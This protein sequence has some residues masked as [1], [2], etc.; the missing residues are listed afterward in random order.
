MVAIESA[1][2]SDVGKKREE[3]ED[4]YLVD[5]ELQL[6]LVADGMGGH[7]AGE[8]ASSM[9]VQAI[10]E[11]LLAERAAEAG[12]EADETLSPDANRLLA[13]VKTANRVVV[14]R[15]QQEEQCR[16]MGSTVS[17][18]YYV[19]STVIAANVGDS[20]IYLVRRGE[21]EPLYV[22]HT[23]VAEQAAIDPERAKMLD[24]RYHSVLTRAIGAASEVV[25]DISEMPLFP[26]DMIILCSD[27]LSNKV[28]PEEICAIVSENNPG[29]SCRRLV[30]L[31]NE[32]GG[33]DNITVVV[34]KA[35]PVPKKTVFSFLVTILERCRLYCNKIIYKM[36]GWS[37]ADFDA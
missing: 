9:V 1:G 11:C 28:S 31:A 20:P 12:Q 5:D 32:R 8:V 24:E 26:G 21:I 18:I 14:E 33:D 23:L 22:P 29:E 19:D 25:P 3:N 10:R 17:A 37:N 4:S 15:A 35:Q 34:L 7:L 30:D 13:G 16:G 6:Y 36:E 2:L 27:G